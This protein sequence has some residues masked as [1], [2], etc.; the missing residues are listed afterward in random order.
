M[1][2]HVEKL[3]QLKSRLAGLRSEM[4]SLDHAVRAETNRSQSRDTG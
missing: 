1:T 4:S 3:S 2:P